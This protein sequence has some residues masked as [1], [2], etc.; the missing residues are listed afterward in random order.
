[1][2]QP[3]GLSIAGKY[4]YLC[5]D[6]LKIF[7]RTKD[8]DLKQLSHVKNLDTYD[9]IALDETH[10]LVVGNDG[11]LQFDVSDPENPRRIST[12]WVEK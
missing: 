6:G 8:T 9:A 10:L 7:D 2:K 1:M 4:L 5:D 12:L 3:K 11:F